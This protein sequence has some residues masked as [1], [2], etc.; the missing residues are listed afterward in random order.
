TC[1]AREQDGHLTIDVIVSPRA[2]R[3]G[4]GPVVGDRLKI[5]VTAP[6]VDGEANAAV[7][8][9][10]AAAAGV[11]RRDVEIVRGLTGRRKTLRIRGGSL[12]RLLEA[13]QR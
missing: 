9:V 1:N 12:A 7:I 10:V 6:P 3:A 2:S 4:V 8:E 11:A 13:N 5:A